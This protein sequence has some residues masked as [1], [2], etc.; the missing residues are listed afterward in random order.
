MDV[1]QVQS[2]IEAVNRVL[3]MVVARSVSMVQDLVAVEAE[4]AAAQAAEPQAA[5]TVRPVELGLGEQ[6]D[7][8]L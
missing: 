3:A 1:T 7:L 6:I 4:L 5:Q 2:S 8:L